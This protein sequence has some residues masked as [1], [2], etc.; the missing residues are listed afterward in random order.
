[1]K[2]GNIEVNAGG[3]TFGYFKTGETHGGFDVHIP[4]HVVKGVNEG[5]VLVVQSGLSGLEIEPALILPHVVDELD[6]AEM[7]GTIVLVP[8]MNTSGFEFEQINSAWDDKNLNELGKGRADGTVSEQMVH[9]YYQEVLS[10]ADALIDVHSGAQ[11]SYHRYASVYDTGDAK[12]SRALATALGLEQ[13]VIMSPDD[14]S[15]A[16]SLAEEGRAV[17]SLNVGGGPGLREFREEDMARIRQAIFNGMKHLGMLS[18]APEYESEQVTVIAAHT[19]LKP[20][21]ARGFTFIDSDK[22][23][24]HVESGE[25]LGYVRH[26]FSGEIVET[27]SAPRAGVMV[28]GGASWPVLPEGV[29]LAIL[30][31]V[32]EEADRA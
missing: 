25:A 12:W 30:G 29:T 15:M 16:R 28:D 23:G 5:P 2:F 22:R 17:V 20:S 24:R 4:M 10:Q 21:G 8:L 3:K 9:A 14:Q 18:G 7:A 6:P 31:D 32:V 13:V 11:W 27:I 26:P 19:V 1:M